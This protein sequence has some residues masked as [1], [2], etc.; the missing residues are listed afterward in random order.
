M[1]PESGIEKK[2]ETTEFIDIIGLVNI[3]IEFMENTEFMN[4]LRLLNQLI[5]VFKLF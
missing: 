2:V 4:L 5:L 1:T 3:E